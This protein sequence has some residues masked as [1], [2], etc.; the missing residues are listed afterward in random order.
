MY[1]YF[2]HTYNNVSPHHSMILTNFLFFN[3]LND[4]ATHSFFLIKQTSC[5]N[6]L[7]KGKKRKK[8]EKS[9]RG[10]RPKLLAKEKLKS[11]QIIENP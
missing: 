8:T 1:K 10:D 3:S 9:T 2:T 4:M 11:T 6:L 5:K 7:I